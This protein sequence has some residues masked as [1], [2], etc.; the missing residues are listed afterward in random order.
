MSD[1]FTSAGFNLQQQEDWERLAL[2]AAGQGDTISAGRIT[3]QRWRLDCGVELWAHVKGAGS[4]VGMSIHFDGRARFKARLVKRLPRKSP[5][6]IAVGAWAF[7]TI[8]PSNSSE[9]NDTMPGDFP[10]VFDAPDGATYGNLLLPQI[11]EIQLAAFAFE[12]STYP[13]E[14]AF[15]AAQQHNETPLAARAFIPT[16]AFAQTSNAPPASVLLAGVVL[17]TEQL[18][19]RVGGSQFTWARLETYGGEVD[20]IA[21]PRTIAGDVVTGGVLHGSFWLSGRVTAGQRRKPG[22]MERLAG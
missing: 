2:I 1:P 7:D 10:F 6:D 8:S 20:I 22:F 18:E 4:V 14:A 5:F 21:A 9:K 11:S 12:V 19:N 13:T 3:Y 15:A 16:S 17:Q